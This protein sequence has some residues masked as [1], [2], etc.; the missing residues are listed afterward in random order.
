MRLGIAL[1]AARAVALVFGD[2]QIDDAKPI[3]NGLA[4][5]P[6][7][8]FSTWNQ[9][10]DQIN[11]QLMLDTMDAMERNGLKDAGFKYINL[12]DGWQRYTGNRSYHPGPIEADPVKFPRGLFLATA[13]SENQF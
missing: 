11:E 7:M 3:S 5:T 2:Q 12:D 6:P 13:E 10:G 9:F 8:G 4:K 1:I